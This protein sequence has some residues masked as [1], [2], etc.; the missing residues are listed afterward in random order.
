MAALWAAWLRGV[1]D[2]TNR[3][4]LESATF[5]REFIRKT[6]GALALRTDSAVRYEKGQDP[7]KAK[8]AIFRLAGLLKYTCPDLKLGPIHGEVLEPS[9]RNKIELDLEFYYFPA[10]I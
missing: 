10:W 9:R 7:E 4:F 3:V 1:N 5:H 6:I 2:E 8:P